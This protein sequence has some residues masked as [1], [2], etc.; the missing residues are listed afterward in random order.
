MR[1]TC[2]GVLYAVKYGN[3]FDFRS[4]FSGNLSNEKAADILDDLSA[5][6]SNTSVNENTAKKLLNFFGYFSSSAGE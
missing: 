5:V 2:P 4:I 3:F 1:L 6:I